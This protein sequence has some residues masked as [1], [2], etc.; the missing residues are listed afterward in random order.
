MF[1][2]GAS[3]MVNAQA[4]E[5]RLVTADR[6]EVDG[7][8]GEDEVRVARREGVGSDHVIDVVCDVGVGRTRLGP[9]DGVESLLGEVPHVV[10]WLDDDRLCR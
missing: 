1:V 4:P 6:R 10:A 7:L 9:V 2:F 5:A 3:V 8:A